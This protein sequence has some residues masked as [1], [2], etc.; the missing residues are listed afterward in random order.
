MGESNTG[1][2]RIQT[3]F[4]TTASVAQ[5]TEQWV[6]TVR[7]T[8]ILPVPSTEPPEAA[9]AFFTNDNWVAAKP[10]PTPKPERRKNVRRSSVGSAAERPRC[11]LLTSVLWV[12]EAALPA[13]F[14][15][16]NMMVSPACFRSGWFCSTA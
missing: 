10:T 1:S 3:P 11:K 8:S 6:Q 13:V 4:S 15:V 5:P 14:F 12:R 7:R 9:S 2:C 16:S